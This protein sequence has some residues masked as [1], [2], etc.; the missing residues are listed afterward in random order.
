MLAHLERIARQ[1]VQE[2]VQRGFAGDGVHLVLEDAGQAPVL[3]C[4]RGH[5]DFTGNAVRDVADQLDELGIG[6]FVSKVLGDKF[7]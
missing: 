5:F 3:R 2:Q 6:V 7:F 1:H 4:L